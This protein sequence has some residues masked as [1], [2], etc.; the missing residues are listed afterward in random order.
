MRYN[1]L[2][3]ILFIS[4][5]FIW[6]SSFIL[7]KVSKQ[8]LTG[9]QIASLR[10]FAAGVVLIP[11]ALAHHSKVP[12]KKLWLV[13]IA[14]LTGNLLPAYLYATAIS[15][16]L[17]SSLAGIL[18]SLT[19]IFVVII[20]VLFFKD[21]VQR[22]KIIGVLAGFAGLCLLFLHDTSHIE[23]IKFG[24]LILLA[25]II[26]GININVVSHTLPGIKPLHIA[27]VS[28]A[29]MTL[30]AG[31]LLWYH[32]FFRLS[33]SD[34]VIRRSVFM[35]C[36]LGIGGSAIATMLF[37]LLVKKAGGLFASLVAY[38]I[39]FIALLWGVIYGEN[40]TVYQVAGLGIILVGVYLAN[41]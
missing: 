8:G 7:M 25:T 18:N 32:D 39:P 16:N 2:K 21:Y 12:R 31:L 20:G 13:F 19:P 14:G 3:W 30:P 6:G 9:S 10:I 5:S 37:Y 38:G 17:D 22:R 4:L 36:L 41:K 34:P 11:F 27:T 35:S 15:H 1:L 33:F 28:V 24:S 29:M 40:I 23:N 26:Y